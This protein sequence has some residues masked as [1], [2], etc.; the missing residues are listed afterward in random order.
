M[1]NSECRRSSYKRAQKK[2]RAHMLRIRASIV[3]CLLVLFFV[4]VGSINV[5]AGS[6]GKETA[7][8]E[9]SSKVYTSYVVEQGDSLYSIAKDHCDLKYYDSYEDYILEIQDINHISADR[10]YY[11]RSITIP[12]YV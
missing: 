6:D 8:A 2:R 10:I 11:G 7:T 12:L 1:R 5:K 9:A 4:G 3:L